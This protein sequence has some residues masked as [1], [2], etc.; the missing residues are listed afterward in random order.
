MKILLA[1]VIVFIG[2]FPVASAILGYMMGRKKL[3][4]ALLA[5]IGFCIFP[6]SLCLFAFWVLQDRFY[7]FALLFS[8]I[9]AVLYTIMLIAGKASAKKNPGN[10][11]LAKI[12]PVLIV[13]TVFIV[14]IIGGVVW[15]VTSP[16]YIDS[17]ADGISYAYWRFD[18]QRHP[19]PTVKTDTVKEKQYEKFVRLAQ[20]QAKKGTVNFDEQEKY[21][22]RYLDGDTW[23]YSAEDIQNATVF[24]R[25]C[26]VKI[27][28]SDFLATP[29]TISSSM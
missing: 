29:Y 14:S 27:I 28:T 18:L 9:G 13:I 15:N 10:T 1:C 22:G 25:L 5:G 24:E 16:S 20:E 12:S 23:E 19:M 17:R 21:L 3:I 26:M 11:V 4:S 7:A 6:V 2:I 8:I